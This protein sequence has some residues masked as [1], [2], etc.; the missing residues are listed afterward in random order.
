MARPPVAQTNKAA[1]GFSPVLINHRPFRL[2]GDS[3]LLPPVWQLAAALREKVFLHNVPLMS[4]T[5][6]FQRVAAL[7][8]IPVGT[9]KVVQVGDR[10]IAIFQYD[11]RFFAVDDFCP[12]RGASLGE[13]FVDKGRVL[14]P[15]HLFDFD[16]GTGACGTMPH[17]R[18]RT[19]NV[20]VEDDAVWIEL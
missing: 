7:A 14:C 4:E 10:D 9:G 11:Q 20:K 1:E 6:N 18:V 13:G 5:H 8:E 19:Y 15:L 17:L 3:G 12:H 2:R 16:L